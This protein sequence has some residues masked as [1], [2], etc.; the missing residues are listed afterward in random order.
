M[1]IVLATLGA[2]SRIEQ[3]APP[4]LLFRPIPKPRI[5]LLVVGDSLSISLG[6]QLERYFSRYSDRIRFQ[7]EGKTSSG[8]A[9]PDFYNW[10]QI[11]STL[12]TQQSRDIVVMMIGANDNKSL[13]TDQRAIAF[14]TDLWRREYGA[15]MQRL[16]EICRRGN[17]R[18][19]VFWMGI[20]IMRD[21]N[22][23]KEA[24]FINDTIEF[25]C[26][27]NPACT[28]VG[29]WTTLADKN[30]DY[31]E[32]VVDERT[33]NP[34]SLRAKDGVHL[35]SHGSFLLSEVAINAMR[36]HYSFDGSLHGP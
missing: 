15:R 17:P 12:V 34:L 35:A 8:L 31:T 7:R 27:K 32:F 22:F 30:G 23:A 11:L 6:E 28:F 4:S 26:R 36:K 24:E 21:S 10:E 2:P 25:W 20:P 19:H 33:G 16:V 5:S 14:G 13:Q 1:L 29:T 18:V 9:R 3:S